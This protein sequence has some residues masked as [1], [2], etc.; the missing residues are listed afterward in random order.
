MIDFLSCAVQNTVTGLFSRSKSWPT[1]CNCMDCSIPAFPALHHL[2]ELAQTHIHWVND[3]IQPSHTL[4]P[5]FS[6]CPQCLLNT[7]VENNGRWNGFSFLDEVWT[8]EMTKWYIAGGPDQVCQGLPGLAWHRSNRTRPRGF[9]ASCKEHRALSHP[10]DFLLVQQQHTLMCP[11]SIRKKP[12]EGKE[13]I[14]KGRSRCA[15]AVAHEYWWRIRGQ[16]RLVERWQPRSRYVTP[17]LQSLT[18]N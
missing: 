2:L 15:S 10:R 16:T 9:T 5:T 18:E 13:K 14:L 3:A 11:G 17:H 8:F 12:R 6:S 1:L 4:S 7:M